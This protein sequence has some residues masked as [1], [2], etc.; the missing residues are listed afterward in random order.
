MAAGAASHTKRPVVNGEAKD[1]HVVRV[2]HAVAPP[3]ALPARHEVGRPEADLSKKREVALLFALV[4]GVNLWVV[5]LSEAEGRLLLSRPL[6]M[7]CGCWCD[8][9]GRGG[10]EAQDCVTS[11]TKSSSCLVSSCLPGL[12]PARPVTGSVFRVIS[13]EP[14]LCRSGGGGWVVIVPPARLSAR[15]RDLPR[16]RTG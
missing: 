14:N 10:S 16:H 6:R 11:M 5:I 15:G 3:N 13:K 7:A 2:E 4:G 8:E 1:A 9:K 12:G